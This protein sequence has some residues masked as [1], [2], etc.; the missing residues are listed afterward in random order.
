MSELI[1]YIC[2]KESADTGGCVAILLWQL[3]VARND[4]VWNWEVSADQLAAMETCP[5]DEQ[6]G[7][8]CSSP[9]PAQIRWEKPYHGW[10][11]C[12]VDIA[13]QTPKGF[14]LQGVL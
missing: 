2:R 1:F 9:L 5:R 11:K 14:Q 6:S 4:V 8:E 7:E 3:W 12:N 10:L 13:F